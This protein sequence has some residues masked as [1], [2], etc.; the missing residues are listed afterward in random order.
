MNTVHAADDA[1]L[2]E[3][4]YKQEFKRAFK[5]LEVFGIAFSIIGLLPSIA[6]VL[7]YALPNGG[8]PAM[9]WG[10]LTASALILLVALSMAELASSAPT[11]GGLYFWT[12]ALAGPRARTVL[13]WVVGYA[14]TIGSVAAVASIDWGCAVQIMA[15]ANI[16]SA[17]GFEATSGD[18]TYTLILLSHAVLCC[19]GTRALAR[20]QGVYVGVNV[21]LCLAVIVA[22]PACTP[23]EF[24]NSA[25]FALGGEGWWN[26][27]GWP[28][29]YA[30]IMSFLAPLWTICSFDSAVH[31]SEEASNAA[32]AVPQAIV[33]AVGVAGGLGVAINISLAFCMGGDLTTLNDADQPMAEI[34]RRGFGREGT[35]AVWAFVVAVQYMMGSSMLLAASRQTFAFSRD[36][37]LPFSRWL[38]RMNAW[39]GTPVNTV[40]FVATLSLLLGLL[41][42]AGDQAINA[43]FSLSVIAL[44]IAY[45][46]PILARFAGDN[47]FKPG[48]FS[49]GWF[50]LPCAIIAVSFMTLMS[51]VFLFPATPLRADYAA[52]M[53]YSVVVLGGVLGLSLVYY[54]FPRW[55][56]VHWFKGPVATIGEGA[57][58][59]GGKGGMIGGG[60]GVR[61]EGGAP[62][63]MSAGGEH[64]DVEKGGDLEKARGDIEKGG[65]LEKG[66]DIGAGGKGRTPTRKAASSSDESKKSE[67]D[68]DVREV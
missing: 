37:A 6:S 64:G 67:A 43:V 25:G 3:L 33:G 32:R 63:A 35:L 36:G 30:F 60:E 28:D 54:Y 58:I 21:C 5:P 14:N 68:V 24:R 11:S 39:T 1:L 8:G 59:V 56:G 47:D 9:V 62:G 34:F 49:L 23:A 16:G 51:V 38:Y 57:M 29:G 61:G 44:Y 22:L 7:F 31:I 66:G 55:G 27:N 53:N 26:V 4:G 12:F 17:E 20:M 10:W 19:V 41:A 40:W 46:I 15:A 52:N 65:G 42:F 18:A 2:A 45:T 50:S 48:P 13:C